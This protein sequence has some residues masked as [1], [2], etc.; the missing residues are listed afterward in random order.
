MHGLGSLVLKA[1]DLAAAAD[2]GL[3]GLLESLAEIAVEVG[4]DDGVQRRVEVA[5]P[6]QNLDNDFGAV[7]VLATHR[8]RDIPEKKGKPAENKRT[9]DDAE[10]LGRLV[11]TL[12]LVDGSLGGGGLTTLRVIAMGIAVRWGMDI[13]GD[14]VVSAVAGAVVVHHGRANLRLAHELLLTNSFLVDLVVGKQHDEAGYPER[15]AGG[16]DGIRLV[17][18]EVADIRVEVSGLEVLVGG[19]PAQEDR[20]KADQSRADP[21]ACYHNAN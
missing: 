21:Y 19:V 9:H 5:D 18:S 12:H 20:D 13:G 16:D 2:E 17:D 14:R 8:D 3:D 7:A 10:G 4:I 1:R 6:E 11:L 15:D